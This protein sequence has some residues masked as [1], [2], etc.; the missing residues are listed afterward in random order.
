MSQPDRTNWFHSREEM[1]KNFYKRPREEEEEE[2]LTVTTDSEDNSEEDI[3]EPPAKY[4]KY[5][6]NHVERTIIKMMFDD[7]TWLK[8]PAGDGNIREL[9]IVPMLESEEMRRVLLLW[10]PSPERCRSLAD[11]LKFLVQCGLEYSKEKCG[12]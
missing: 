9:L 6:S 5:G 4:A 10:T 12:I 2:S 8:N 11:E 1:K 7:G 3:P